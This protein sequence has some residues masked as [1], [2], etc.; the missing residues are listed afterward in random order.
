MTQLF[1]N[2]KRYVAIISWLFTLLE[3][4]VGIVFGALL[5]AYLADGSYRRSLLAVGLAYLA[6][7]IAKLATQR[8][9]PSAVVEELRSRGLLAEARK[10][11]DRRTVVSGFITDSI[12]ALN[13]QTCAI[14]SEAENTLCSQAVSTGLKQVIEPLISRPQYVFDCNESRFT[15]ACLVNYLSPTSRDW[16]DDFIVFRDDFGVSETLVPSLLRDSEARGSLLDLQ[17]AM[18]RC[19]N[20]N[21]FV[22]DS[23]T[24]KGELLSIVASPIPLVCESTQA[25]GILLF[26]S[27]PVH[28]CPHDVEITFRIFGRIIANWL[29]KYSECVGARLS[30][31]PDLSPGTTAIPSQT[32][33]NAFS[34]PP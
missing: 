7:L 12:T 17:K 18:Q 20:D 2:L 6:L 26:V 31:P 25:N 4:A 28:Q 15:V 11:L 16:T 21:V 13:A 30:E 5:G 14:N 27:R 34:S 8:L 24:P 32:S 33:P 22:C 10:Q 23:F 9:F 19:F 1:D 3:T 29:A